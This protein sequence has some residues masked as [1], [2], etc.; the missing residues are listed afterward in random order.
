MYSFGLNNVNSHGSFLQTNLA[1]MSQRRPWFLC[2]P[3]PSSWVFQ[4]VDAGCRI[5]PRRHLKQAHAFIY[6]DGFSVR[7]RK[8]IC[9]SVFRG[10]L[11]HVTVF[12]FRFLS[13]TACLSYVHL[14]SGPCGG[15]LTP[16]SLE[17][18]DISGWEEVEMWRSACRRLP[19]HV[20][21]A[22]CGT[23]RSWCRSRRF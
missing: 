15:I 19:T 10:A 11:T 5:M 2:S 6:W 1:K 14:L 18:D 12:L 21:G 16:G 7:R 22:L 17:W 3:L 4:L 20:S 13:F 8:K 9:L 23:Q